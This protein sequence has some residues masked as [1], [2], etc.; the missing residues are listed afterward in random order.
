MYNLIEYSD[1][2]SN[3]SGSLWKYYIDEQALTNACAIASFHVAK[4]GALFK[5]KQKITG[6]T[7]DGGTN[8]VEIMV[9]LKYLS[10][11]RRTLEISLINCEINLILTGSDKC[12]LSSDTK[13]ETFAVIDTRFF[14]P[15]VTL[16]TQYNEKLL[17]QLKPGFKR[18]IN[19]N[20]YE[21]K[22]TKPIF[23]FLS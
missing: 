19:W 2:Y 23:R 15:V 20:K 7:A 8:D 18:T 4:S 3:T 5:C 21:P 22:T 9:S 12:V 11:F 16:L 10:T 6:K 1:S 14:L 17:E 13:A